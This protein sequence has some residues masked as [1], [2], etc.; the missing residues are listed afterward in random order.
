MDKYTQILENLN[1]PKVI[2]SSVFLLVAV[3]IRAVIA[4]HI[5]RAKVSSP[6]VRR[7]WMVNLRNGMLLFITGGLILIWARELQTL[8]LS[9][10]AIA[11][12]LVIATKELILCISG[13]VLR[14]TSDSYTVGDRIEINGLRGDVIDHTLLATTLLEIGPGMASHQHTGR[15]IV[16]PNSLM[17]STPVIN[18]TYT[19][20]YVL[21]HFSV[22]VGPDR[23]WKRAEEILLKASQAECASYMDQ[24]RLHFEHLQSKHSIESPNLEPRVSIQIP[25]HEKII[26]LVRLP[27]PARRKGRIEQSI[28]RKFMA[29]FYGTPDAPD[30]DSTE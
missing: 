11:A 30:A 20:A 7:R 2:A 21:H 22:P 26:L 23:D 3:V 29:D 15:T 18:E 8:V 19:D 25:D 6:E 13:N 9:I 27:T 1:V 16:V 17:V 10:F 4:T 12:A 24:A 14:A 28:L 5:H